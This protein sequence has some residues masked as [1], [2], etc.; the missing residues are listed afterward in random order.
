MI[1]PY[2]AFCIDSIE[3]NEIEFQRRSNLASHYD[4]GFKMRLRCAKK[5]D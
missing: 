2:H 4:K 5:E 3:A 1:M